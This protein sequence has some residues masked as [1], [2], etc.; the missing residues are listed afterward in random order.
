MKQVLHII[1]YLNLLHI[2]LPEKIKMSKMEIIFQINLE[3]VDWYFLI[4][5][6]VKIQMNKNHQLSHRAPSPFRL[7]KYTE[8]KELFKAEYFQI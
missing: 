5:S 2:I 3:N 4:L 8:H 6:D 7:I 1:S